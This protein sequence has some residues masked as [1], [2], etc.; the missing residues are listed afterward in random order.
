MGILAEPTEY[1]AKNT[2][3]LRT[4]YKISITENFVRSVAAWKAVFTW[5]RCF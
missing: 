3:S 2:I 1:Y 5:Q 4:V